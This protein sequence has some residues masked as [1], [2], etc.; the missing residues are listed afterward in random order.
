MKE[1]GWRKA[2]ANGGSQAARPSGIG[3]QLRKV[4]AARERESIRFLLSSLPRLFL[5]LITPIYFSLTLPRSPRVSTLAQPFLSYPRN[6]P[7]P[8]PSAHSATSAPPTRIFKKAVVPPSFSLPLLRA[9]LH[10]FPPPFPTL[11]FTRDS[12]RRATT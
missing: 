5:F 4:T 10:F 7:S 3:R 9:H 11:A 2:K 12:S 8:H 6:R 1:G